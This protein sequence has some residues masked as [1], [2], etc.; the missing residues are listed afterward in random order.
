MARNFGLSDLTLQ[1]FGATP[2]A[3]PGMFDPNAPAN[4]T[5]EQ[6]AQMFQPFDKKRAA[7]EEQMA[8]ANALRGGQAQHHSTGL[9][10]ALGALAQ[11]IN[12]AN[13]GY[14]AHQTQQQMAALDQQ[15]A[16]AESKKFGL[17][18]A[19]EQQKQA[20]AEALKRDE[21]ALEKLKADMRAKQE[22][23]KVAAYGRRHKGA[24]SNQEKTLPVTAVE[25][26]ADTDVA[27][28]Q[29]DTL[30][31]SF[32]ENDQ[33]S[34]MGKMGAKV[35]KAL[36]LQDTDAAKYNADVMRVNQAVGK[37]LEGGKLAAGDEEKYR[38]MQPMAGDSIDIVRKKIDGM[39][40]F[41]DDIKAGRIKAYKAS[42]YKVPGEDATANV[43]P[44]GGLSPEKAKRL[45]ELR[46]K[47]AAGVLK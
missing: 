20:R 33:G 22:A 40:A 37:I 38:R 39:K 34:F 44:A 12:G 4:L 15:Q 36:G 14:Q 31:D 47:K 21:L 3:T 30:D 26:L 16:V 10:G 27:K 1:P 45:E 13:G 2:Q 6:L 19:I 18:Q 43:Q 17:L 25:A 9:G 41:L 8:L 35:T 42:G 5:P 23:A 7:L 11:G 46:K 29:L 28:N 32:E 24:G